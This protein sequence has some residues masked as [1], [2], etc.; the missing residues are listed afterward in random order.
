MSSIRIVATGPMQRSAKSSGMDS[1][2]EKSP[3]SSICSMGS[4][5]LE[6]SALSVIMFP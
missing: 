6:F 3:Y 5:S 1:K 2:K 4:L